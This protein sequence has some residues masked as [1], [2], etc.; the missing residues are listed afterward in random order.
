MQQQEQQELV[1]WW[2][3]GGVRVALGRPEA[4]PAHLAAKGGGG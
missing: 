1:G 3:G 4:S 2:G